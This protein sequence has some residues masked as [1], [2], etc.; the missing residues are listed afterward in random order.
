MNRF[1]SCALSTTLV[2]MAADFLPAAELTVGPDK[3]FQRIEDALAKAQNGDTILVWPR[4]GS[5]AYEKVAV[6]VTKSHITFKASWRDRVALSGKGFDYSGSGSTPRAI[7]QFN[8]GADG[9]VLEGFELSGA[10]NDSHNGAGVRIN[11]ANDVTV[12][13]CSIHDNDMG[14][15][16]N[17][18]GTP[19]TAADQRIEACLIHAN[20]NKAEPGYNHNLYL[21]GTS[22]TLL[23][24][25]VHSSLTGHNVKSRAHLTV[26]AGCY[27]HDSANREFDLVDAKGDTTGRRTATRCWSGNVIVKAA[28][29][30]GNRGVIHFGQD[31]GNEHD[32]TIT[33]VHNTIVTPY[34]SPVVSLDAPKARVQ[35]LNNI[36]WDGGGRQQGQKL[37]DTGKAGKDAATGR[38]NLVAPGFGANAAAWGGLRLLSANLETRHCSSI[39]PRV[40]T[41][42]RKM[43]YWPA[44][45]VGR[46]LIPCSNHCTASSTSMSPGRATRKRPMRQAGPGAYEYVDKG[47]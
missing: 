32:G 23:G 26:V 34:I 3:P 30:E 22:V 27:I 16:S 5:A 29:C 28:Q 25:E 47:K 12:R 17:G 36:I 35:F 38:D 43:G 2:L 10:H 11:Q 4:A 15:M 13:N 20:G 46:P 9:C 14:I 31:G 40:T 37:V 41:T 24:C 19:K 1:W 8:R 18:D 7:F 6:F 33:L 21:G 39:L 44:K 45:R 42:W